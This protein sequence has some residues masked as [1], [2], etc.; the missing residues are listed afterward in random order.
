MPKNRKVIKLIRAF[1]NNPS[2][3]TWKQLEILHKSPY[4]CILNY[5]VKGT[6]IKCPEECPGRD[7]I[8]EYYC[9]CYFSQFE[10]IWYEKGDRAKT[11]IYM[12]RFLA[13]AESLEQCRSK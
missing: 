12:I 8:Y 1:I 4:R 2:D 9:L 7:V 13:C 10:W 5:L 6:V 11:V 3:E